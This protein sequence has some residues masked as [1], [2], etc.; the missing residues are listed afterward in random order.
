MAEP[1]SLFFSPKFGTLH[2]DDGIG[3]TYY[4]V[5]EVWANRVKI[6]TPIIT[7]S[8]LRTTFQIG[9]HEDCWVQ[10]GAGTVSV[11]SP[12][13][14]QFLVHRPNRD[15]MGRHVFNT[16][17]RV[18]VT[19]IYDQRTDGQDWEWVA[20]AGGSFKDWSLIPAEY[21]HI[22]D[23]P[24]G[25]Y[26]NG[27]RINPGDQISLFGDREKEAYLCLGSTGKIFIK[28]GAVGEDSTALPEQV[29]KL[30]KWP[31]DE[32]VRVESLAATQKR[33]EIEQKRIAQQNPN[34]PVRTDWQSVLIDTVRES[35]IRRL[36]VYTIL[37]LSFLVV[38]LILR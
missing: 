7:S 9:R 15:V 31:S 37:A 10:F 36:V 11:L 26:L 6:A 20:M 21:V 16:W 14:K 38:F 19:L 29:W 24:A 28:Q 23:P 30:G 34:K 8:F 13:S 17:S 22:N 33:F 27:E 35:P 3:Q 4:V 1:I 25:V 2:R 12:D 18:M 5:D 32:K